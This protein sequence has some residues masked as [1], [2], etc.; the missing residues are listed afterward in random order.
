MV[1]RLNG[2]IHGIIHR[3]ITFWV[4]LGVTLILAPVLMLF[5]YIWLLM[6]VTEDGEE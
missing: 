1:A 5:L 6:L 2:K 3:P 4:R